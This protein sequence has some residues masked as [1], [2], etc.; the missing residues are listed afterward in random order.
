MICNHHR[1]KDGD[2]QLPCA[3]PNCDEGTLAHAL[4]TVRFPDGPPRLSRSVDGA[5]DANLRYEQVIWDRRQMRISDDAGRPTG[6][7]AFIWLERPGP[8][9]CKAIRKAGR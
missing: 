6:Y 3:T 4:V 5:P 8:D 7:S 9:A 1:Q 2:N